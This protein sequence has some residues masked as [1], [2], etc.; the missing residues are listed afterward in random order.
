MSCALSFRFLGSQWKESR[1][2]PSPRHGAVAIPSKRNQ[3]LAHLRL[4]SVTMACGWSEN[5][6]AAVKLK[7]LSVFR[8]LS[9]AFFSKFET[10]ITILTS[11]KKLSVISCGLK[12]FPPQTVHHV[13]SVGGRLHP[14]LTRGSSKGITVLPPQS[15]HWCAVR[16]CF[17]QVRQT[18]QAP[19]SPPQSPQNRPT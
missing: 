5:C 13:P 15:S 16:F 11:S 10:G 1:R 14:H 3:I 7:S 6:L 19:Y 18:R 8:K 4:Y 17:E 9:V 12:D 2:F